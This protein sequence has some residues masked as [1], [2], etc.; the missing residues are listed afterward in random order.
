MKMDEEDKKLIRTLIEE[1][2]RFI[3]A[4]DRSQPAYPGS[5]MTKGQMYDALLATANL[6][7]PNVET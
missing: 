5:T 1:L 3:A 7:P 2:R 4:I 6:P